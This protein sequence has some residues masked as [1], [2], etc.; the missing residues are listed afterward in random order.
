VVVVALVRPV[1]GVAL[2]AAVVV[3]AVMLQA[4]KLLLKTEQ[5]TH[6]VLAAAVVVTEAPVLAVMLTV[7]LEVVVLDQP[8]LDR[9]PMVEALVE[10]LLTLTRVVLP[11]VVAHQAVI[12][13]AQEVVVPAALVVQILLNPVALVEVLLIT[14]AAVLLALVVAL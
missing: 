1:D 7:V 5:V 6:L 12:P 2:V 4:P 14:A 9:L 8:H 13:G 11:V 3:A 10:A